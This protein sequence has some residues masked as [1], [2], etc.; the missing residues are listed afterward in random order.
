MRRRPPRSTLFPYAT[1]FRSAEL[2]QLLAEAAGGRAQMAFVTGESGVGKTRLVGELA[3][4]AAG[5]GGGGVFGGCHS[6]R[7]GGVPHPPLVSPPPPP[8]PHRHPGPPG[9]RC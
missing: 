6:R 4:R 2:E 5:D 9:L 1:L 7:S 8:P 3:P